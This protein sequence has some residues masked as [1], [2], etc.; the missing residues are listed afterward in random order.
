MVPDKSYAFNAILDYPIHLSNKE[1]DMNPRNKV[2]LTLLVFVLVVVTIACSCSDLT[3]GGS[4]GG[5]GGSSSEPIP[6]LAG[7]W[8]DVAENNVHTIVWDGSKYTVASVVDDSYGAYTI[9]SQSWDGSSLKWTYEASEGAGVTIWTT[10]VSGDT[11]NV[12]WSSSNGNSG[13]DSFPREP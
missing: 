6:G 12:G 2:W 10:S 9:S 8:R 5:S 4:S 3:G 13:T 11:L 1:Y 7:K